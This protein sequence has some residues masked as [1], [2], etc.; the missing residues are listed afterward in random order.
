[1]ELHALTWAAIGLVVILAATSIILYVRLRA[2]TKRQQA[3]VDSSLQHWRESA[4]IVALAVVQ[5]QCDLS[6]GCLRLRYILN[7]LGDTRSVLELMG[8]ELAPFATHKKRQELELS[9]RFK[10]DQMRLMIE[11]K[12][13]VEFLEVCREIAATYDYR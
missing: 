6:E 7:Q 8:E 5:E 12:F 1:M 3:Q 13:R 10:Q 11:E 9:E 4:R 2:L